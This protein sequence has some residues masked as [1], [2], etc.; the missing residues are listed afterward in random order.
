[1]TDSERDQI[2]QDAQIFMRTCS[3][4]I[5]QLRNEGASIFNWA[6]NYLSSSVRPTASVIVSVAEKQVVLAQIKEHRGAVLDLIEMYLKGEFMNTVIHHT[7][8]WTDIYVR[9]CVCMSLKEC[10]SCTLSSGQYEWKKSWT[11]KERECTTP[12][13]SL[14]LEPPLVAHLLVLFSDHGWHQSSTV[15]QQK[16]QS[17]R[18][19]RR[20]ARRRKVLVSPWFHF[21]APHTSWANVHLKLG[22]K[23]R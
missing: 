10:V 6:T 7:H 21:R 8:H 12:S 2:D 14:T 13:A 18:K 16:L 4:A 9:V 23:H 15:W 3:E 1:M 19:Q 11:R 5:R 20:R 22:H 17:W